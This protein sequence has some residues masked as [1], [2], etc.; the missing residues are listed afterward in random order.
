MGLLGGGNSKWN[1]DHQIDKQQHRRDMFGFRTS[2]RPNH[3]NQRQAE[4]ARVQA[5]KDKKAEN[6]DGGLFSCATLALAM[7]GGVVAL[8][9]ALAY[10]VAKVVI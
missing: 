6:G 7:A 5:R 1:A 8:V 9:A 3:E 10:G 2:S 4:L